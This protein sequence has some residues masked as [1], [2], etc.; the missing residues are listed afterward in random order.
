[1][2]TI[3]LREPLKGKARVVV[4]VHVDGA[5]VNKAQLA[6]QVLHDLVL[7]IINEGFPEGVDLFNL[8]VPTNYDSEEVKITHL[9]HKMLDKMVIDNTHEEKS[10]IFNYPLDEGQNSDDLVMITSNLVQEYEENSDGHALF[11]EKRL[12]SE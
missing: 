2:G 7:K 11:V 5:A 10:E 6:Q 12:T 8:N 3:R 1:M 9:S 4:F